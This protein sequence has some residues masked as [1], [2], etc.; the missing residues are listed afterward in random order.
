MQEP[1]RFTA[2]DLNSQLPCRKLGPEGLQNAVLSGIILLIRSRRTFFQ[3]AS[4]YFHFPACSRF[5]SPCR[6][7]L[8]RSVEVACGYALAYAATVVSRL[9]VSRQRQTEEIQSKVGEI[10]GGLA[11]AQGV[12]VG[13]VTDS[14]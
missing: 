3:K 8:S 1:S 6:R 14:W 10:L 12:V 7:A 4:L 5:R 2:G 13:G 11:G 9:L